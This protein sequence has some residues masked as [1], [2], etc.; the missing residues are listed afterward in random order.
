ML[1][2]SYTVI[3]DLDTEK[4]DAPTITTTVEWDDG[5][6]ETILPNILVVGNQAPAVTKVHGVL[7]LAPVST[8][9]FLRADATDD[10]QLNVADGIWIL[11]ELFQDGA[12][13]ACAE[14]ADANGDGQYDRTDALY[15]F[16]HQFLDGHEPPAPFP[17]C[18]DGEEEDDCESSGCD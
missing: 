18:G 11:R 10:D 9:Q 5:L 1:K 8:P 14:A 16:E 7:T 4:E 12:A 15:I 3:A 13:S 6:G 2:L 17:D